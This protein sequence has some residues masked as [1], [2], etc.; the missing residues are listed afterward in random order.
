MKI[1]RLL[2]LAC[3]L[4]HASA[5][6]RDGA[7]AMRDAATHDQLAHGLRLVQQED[8][9]KGLAAASGA[10]PAQQNRPADLLD[11]SDMITFNGLS[12]LVPKRAILSIPENLK[13]RIAAGAGTQLVSWSE[14]LV[15]NR[16]WITTEE[17]TYEQA[18]GAESLPEETTQRIGKCANLVVATYL[19]GP[20]SFSAAAPD[21]TSP[22]PKN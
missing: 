19:G 6:P 16:A 12:T 5:S 4:G 22:Q 3:C 14:F 15:A 8:P 10:D 2:A 7:P 21:S 9:M 13:E 17:V 11:R 18:A 20:I 1:H